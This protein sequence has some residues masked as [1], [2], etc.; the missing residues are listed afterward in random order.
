MNYPFLFEFHVKHIRTDF[1]GK[2]T[3]TKPLSVS[4]I[5]KEILVYCM[6]AETTLLIAQSLSKHVSRKTPFLLHRVYPKHVS[7]EIPPYPTLAEE[8]LHISTGTPFFTAHQHE[9]TLLAVLLHVIHPKHASKER[10]PLLCKLHANMPKYYRGT[11]GYI[12]ICNEEH[13]YWL[14]HNCAYTKSE[15]GSYYTSCV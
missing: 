12:K 14:S 4:H 5:S 3:S 10:L 11:P 9:S 13:L 15:G 6:S 1:D 7:E 2:H 8:Y